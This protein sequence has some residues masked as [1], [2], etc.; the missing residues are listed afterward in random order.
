MRAPLSNIAIA[1]SLAVPSALAATG[2]LDP[3]FADHG[4]LA[5]IAGSRG[6][7]LYADAT[8]SGG[9]LVGGSDFEA[10]G[11][12]LNLDGMGCTY[13]AHGSSFVSR[14]DEHGVPD[15]TFESVTLAGIEAVSMTRQA[16]GKIVG[17]GHEIVLVSSY[18]CS[19]TFTPTVFRLNGDGSLDTG[20]GSGGK[21][22][23]PSWNT[24]RS[25]VVDSKG[26]IVVA[27][28]R[29][30]DGDDPST[31]GR[32][33]LVVMRLR[34]DGRLD[35]SFGTDG[36]YLGPKID[37]TFSPLF[38]SRYDGMD[39]IN[40]VR[41]SADSLRIAAQAVGKCLVV[42]L[43]PE[44]VPD[45][46]F[47]ADGVATPRTG[48]GA[49]ATCHVLESDADDRLII[50]GTSRNRGFLARLLA[51]GEPDPAFSADSLIARS[52]TQVTSVA[53]APDGKLLASGTGPR[54]TA[55]V[56]LQVGGALDPAFGD[57]GR[58][59]IDLD[60]DAAARLIVNC[61]AIGGDGSVILAGSDSNSDRPFVVR[62]SGDGG[63]TSRGIIS[64]SRWHSAPQES[65]GKAVLY[66]RRSG[67]SSGA[68]SARF[69]TV[70][71]LEAEP[72]NDF[73]R[74]SG[75]LYWSAGDTSEKAIVVEIT[76]RD[77]LPEALESFHVVLDSGRGGAGLGTRGATVDIQPDGS[78][79]GQIEID[80]LDL[81]ACECSLD[82]QF[83]LL[84][85]YYFEGRVCVTFTTR[86]GTAIAGEDFRGDP[87]IVCWEDGDT[88]WKLPEIQII[89]DNKKEGTET[90]TI[91]LSNPTGGAI[92]GRSGSATVT[93]YDND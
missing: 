53:I 83:I 75:R 26:R 48:T 68:V 92:V 73:V 81:D 42:A 51:S 33:E 91:E 65:D 56:R 55:V 36:R 37:R 54:G 13:R 84:R 15:P 39:K 85:N 62:L 6:Q 35:R 44:G 41:T 25:I 27:G 86:S 52:T 87:A 43:T 32:H 16:D 58:T 3:G 21:K 64:F 82:G 93:L 22:E 9:I 19:H 67:G 90:F 5:P 12:I 70:A 59:W 20:F 34:P 40:V 79:G 71:D 38:R 45:S 30:V 23:W 2:D 57:A 63:G 49:K 76:Q 60:S 77:V 80:L 66:V 46:A 28:T 88:D 50:A 89:D 47:G 69:Q 74:T 24:I 7:A 29:W 14:I 18:R 17:I 31:P 1:F 72:R 11:S 78:P 4:R 61:M 10:S 8:D